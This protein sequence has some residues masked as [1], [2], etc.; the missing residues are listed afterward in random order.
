MDDGGRRC[1][2]PGCDVEIETAS[3]RPERRYCG[4]R[5]RA[6][7]RQARRAA[8]HAQRREA[9]AGG[10]AE[11]LPWLPGAAPDDRGAGPGAVRVDPPG[12]GVSAVR[13]ASASG[14]N[15]SRGGPV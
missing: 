6:A 5:H 11:A 2:L 13:V 15:R 1:A 4:A 7:A 12:D 14:S 10:L 8:V 9:S 3:G